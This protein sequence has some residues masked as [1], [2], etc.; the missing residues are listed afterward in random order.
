MAGISIGALVGVGVA[1]AV[2]IGAA[3]LLKKKN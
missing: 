2:S 1:I 3:I